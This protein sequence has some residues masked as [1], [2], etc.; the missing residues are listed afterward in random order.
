MGSAAA[1]AGALYREE[2]ARARAMDP[3]EKLLEGPRLFD[4]ACRVMLD[5][6]RHQHPEFDEAS[7]RALLIERFN[8]L[9]SLD[10]RLARLELSRRATIH[11]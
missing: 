4:R 5:G 2:I 9:R 7:A 11:A 1:L 3:V 8:L 6:I 10:R